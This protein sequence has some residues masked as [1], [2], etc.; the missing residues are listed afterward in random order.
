MAGTT[1]LAK[2]AKITPKVLPADPAPA[3]GGGARAGKKTAAK[4][5]SPRNAAASSAAQTVAAGGGPED[6]LADLAAMFNGHQAAKQAR[7]SNK[8]AKKPP[9]PKSKAGPSPLTRGNKLLLAEFTVC[10][11][12]LGLGTVV[13][14]TGSK[15]GV[16]RL[17]S[18]GSG[19]CLLF[20]ILSIAAGTGESARRLAGG[21]GGLITLAYLLT[22]SDAKNV[23]GWIT[24]YYTPAATQ[25]GSGIGSIG[26][27]VVAAEN[28]GQGISAVAA[29]AE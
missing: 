19:L 3:A 5:T 20:F 10:F 11:V 18:R 29:A 12:I 7:A 22:S 2:T 16:P 6:P 4:K 17:I 24:S 28:A 14:P 27:A 1:T 9:A 26:G 15:D 25:A 13:A 21:I 8:A 23:F